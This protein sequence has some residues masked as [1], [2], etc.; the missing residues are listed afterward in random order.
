MVLFSCKSDTVDPQ[1][2]F[3]VVVVVVVC[4][5]FTDDSIVLLFQM[6]SDIVPFILNSRYCKTQTCTSHSFI[7]STSVEP[8]NVKLPLYR[9]TVRYIPYY[10][11]VYR[12]TL[13]K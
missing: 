7:T 13:H 2:F 12:Y 8:T 4:S 10:S 5:S 9:T 1:Q 3:L 6:Y 11:T